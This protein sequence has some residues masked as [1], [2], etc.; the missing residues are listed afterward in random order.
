MLRM[1]KIRNNIIMPKSV[2][3]ASSVSSISGFSRHTQPR[4]VSSGSI[5]SSCSGESF[6]SAR[7]RHDSGSSYDHGDDK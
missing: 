1:T 3:C 4:S 7:F 2:M 6:R 5:N